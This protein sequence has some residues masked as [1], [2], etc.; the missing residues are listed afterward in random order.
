MLAGILG[1]PACAR[2][3]RKAGRN[4]RPARFTPRSRS[5]ISLRRCATAVRPSGSAPPRSGSA[6]PPGCTGA[7]R[8]FYRVFLVGLLLLLLLDGVFFFSAAVAVDRL[9]PFRLDGGGFGA[10]ALPSPTHVRRRGDVS[11]ARA[12]CSLC[13][14]FSFF[15]ANRRNTA[16]R[17]RI[18]SIAPLRRGIYGPAFKS[19]ATKSGVQLGLR[20]NDY[21]FGDLK[22]R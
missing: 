8:F 16:S 6:P 21:V 15:F 9:V 18:Y 3:A 20:E 11:K 10:D 4:A 1:V 14:F 13:L 7:R 22:V 19:I 2:E 5:D 17:P 12:S